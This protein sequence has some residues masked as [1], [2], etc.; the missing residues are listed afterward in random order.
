MLI[1]FLPPKQFRLENG[2]P[3][4]QPLYQKYRIIGY[5]QKI[6]L[7]TIR[8]I[9]TTYYFH[10]TTTE[11]QIIGFTELMSS[12][13]LLTTLYRDGI[14]KHGIRIILTRAKLLRIYF[15]IRKKVIISV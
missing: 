8:L 9:Q 11:P 2:M 7:T 6:I 1:L 13:M 10:G 15:T 4:N 5:K 12:A 3:G 14:L